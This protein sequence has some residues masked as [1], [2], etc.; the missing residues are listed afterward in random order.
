MEKFEKFLVS[1]NDSSYINKIELYNQ[2][3]KLVGTIEQKK[4]SEGSIRI[5]SHLFENFGEI[6]FDAATEGLNIYSEYTEDARNNPGKHPNIDRLLS[7]I[8][9]K[10][11]L[12]VKI[13]K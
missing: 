9:T 10:E 8:I 13:I 2:K 1:L 6:N 4:G 11:V 3:N 7:I 12:T 5:Y